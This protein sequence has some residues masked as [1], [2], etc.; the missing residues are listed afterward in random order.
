MNKRNL[1]ELDYVELESLL[2]E[3]NLSPVHARAIWRAVYR[4]GVTAVADIADGVAPA[5]FPAKVRAWLVAE[6]TLRLP[7]L[8]ASET[9]ADGA[10]CKD[11]LRFADGATVEVVQLRY[12]QRYSACISTQVGCAC[13][14]VFCAT[15]QMGFVRQLPASEIVAQVLHVQ[16]ALRR[17]GATLANFVLMGMGE[18]LLNYDHTLAAIRR[19][20]EARGLGF[21]ARRITLSTCGIVPGIRRLADDAMGINLAVSLHAATDEVRA[22]MMPINH[23]YPLDALFAALRDYVERTQRRVMLE[24]VLVAGVTDTLAQARALVARLVGLEAHVNLIQLN[25][26]EAYAARPS[27]PAAVAAFTAVLD[28]AGVPHTMRQRRGGSIAAGCGQLRSKREG[29]LTQRAVGDGVGGVLEAKRDLC[30]A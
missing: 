21:V 3:W 25:P 1:Y 4:D 18:P 20:C 26:T 8:A 10:A 14:C 28:Q 30:D 24:W 17:D 22:Q 6:T 15:G 2:A 11:L 9:S 23:T 27:S 7:S 13:G 19:L 29:V 5:T 12:R 16:Q